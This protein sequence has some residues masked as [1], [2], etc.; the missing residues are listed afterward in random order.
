MYH[1]ID[2]P[3]ALKRIESSFTVLVKNVYLTFGTI[4]FFQRFDQSVLL[5]IYFKL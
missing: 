2:L 3:I 1:I 4:S 5:A